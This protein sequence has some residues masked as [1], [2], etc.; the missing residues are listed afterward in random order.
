MLLE[1]KRSHGKLKVLRALPPFDKPAMV[2]G[3]LADVALMFLPPDGKPSETADGCYWELTNG[4]RLG[5]ERLD[6]G[7]CQLRL[8]NK[9]GVLTREVRMIPP[10]HNGFAEDLELKAS[11]EAAYRLELRLIKAETLV[12]RH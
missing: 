11:G 2:Q 10:W 6:E 12:A 4:S 5:V 1:F 7:G 8:W 9:L 3:L